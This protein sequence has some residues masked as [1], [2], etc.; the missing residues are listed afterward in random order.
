MISHAHR[1]LF[2]HVPKCAGQSVE[3]AFLEDLGLSWADRAPLLLRANDRPELGPPRLAH[4]R[5]RDY[6]RCR[7]LSQE[8]F[9]RYFKFAV[10][11]NP[12]SRVVSLYRHLRW[13]MC[14]ADFVHGWLPEQLEGPEDAW[15]RWF[16]MPQ[17]EFLSD[18]GRMLTD[19]VIKLEDLP[20]AFASI[21][22]AAGVETPLPHRNRSGE[23]RRQP[24]ATLWELAA[25]VQ[26]F[27]ALPVKAKLAV[28]GL[29]LGSWRREHHEDWRDFYHP[30][31]IDAV[32]SLYGDDVLAFGYTF[33]T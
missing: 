4:L 23:P 15:M 13:N 6:V 29:V 17:R 8:L 14:F 11:R 3:R 26:P 19:A 10:V 1:T 21:A 28:L 5:A 18:G 7:Y 24:P 20:G 30:G 25:G 16:V 31:T 33:D 2:F 9:E 22:R 27:L 32:G 12:W